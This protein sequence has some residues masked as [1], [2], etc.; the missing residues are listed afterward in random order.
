MGDVDVSVH[1][2]TATALGRG[3]VASPTL[4]RLYPGNA[5][6]LD[7]GLQE[8][9]Y[10]SVKFIVR[11]NA[12]IASSAVARTFYKDSDSLKRSLTICGKSDL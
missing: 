5:K 3:R 1:I 7:A 9:I 2:F 8:R 11:I 12:P 6:V 10:R 4:G